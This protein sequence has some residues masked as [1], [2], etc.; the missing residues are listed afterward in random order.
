MSAEST[1]VSRC[2]LVVYPV[3]AW[4]GRPIAGSDVTVRL[5]GFPYKPLRMP[6]GGFAFM[7]VQASACSLSVSAPLRPTSRRAVDLAALP[8]QAPVV[9]VPLLPG[10]R[11]P[12][13]PGA[14]G[15]GLQLVDAGGKPLSDVR[16]FAW[17]EEE[18]CSRGR[19][20]DDLPA[21]SDKLRFA[22]EGGRLLPGDRFILAERGGKATERCRVG[23]DTG[24]P[25]TLSLEAP[26]ARDWRRG[27]L[28]LPAAEAL[29]DSDG[30][31]AL[32]LR[33]A[34]PTRFR[35]LAE[36]ALG[37]KRTRA[38]WTATGG[39]VSRQDS[40]AWPAG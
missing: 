12:A 16:I 27:A 10:S 13:P 20:A 15:L 21:G 6:D 29:T 3:D 8:R 30:A 28:L 2:S 35:V 14:T 26:V 34:Y 33:G 39:T 24:Q 5:E 22:A 9:V 1:F 36:L 17:V 19:L 31:A 7:D 11:L 18:S 32:A 37:K 4:T 38:E 40:I 23:P 25:G